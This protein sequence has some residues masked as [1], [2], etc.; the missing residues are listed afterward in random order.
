M[1]PGGGG[2]GG[3]GAI[4]ARPRLPLLVL[5][6][7][8]LACASLLLSLVLALRF[9]VRNDPELAG[10]TLALPTS[11]AAIRASAEG[12]RAVSSRHRPLFLA[13]LGGAYIFK[14]AFSIPGSILANALAGVTLGTAVGG[15]LVLALSCAGA[16]CGYLLSAEFGVEAVRRWG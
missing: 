11:F 1:T 15:P 2:G 13:L 14:Q 10:A 7:L 8:F 6:A 4:G 16:S 3:G 5:P 12:L 9:A